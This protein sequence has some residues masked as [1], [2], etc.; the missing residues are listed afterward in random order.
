MCRFM[1]LGSTALITIK[2][3]S[4]LNKS[5]HHN[6]C[7]KQVSHRY[8]AKRRAIKDSNRLQCSYTTV[9]HV[10]STINYISAISLSWHCTAR[11]EGE[12]NKK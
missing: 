8:H 9:M 4:I 7:K 3:K 11:P 2:K 6:V 10:S 12:K 1:F 5:I